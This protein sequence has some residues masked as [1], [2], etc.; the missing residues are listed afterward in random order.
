MELTLTTPAF[1]PTV[2][3]AKAFLHAIDHEDRQLII[4]I[5]SSKVEGVP[6]HEVVRRHGKLSQQAISKHLQ[7]LSAAGVVEGVPN[8]KKRQETLYFM[9]QDYCKHAVDVLAF[10]SA[11]PWKDP[12]AD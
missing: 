10:F 8:P 1:F 2:W 4:A 9:C 12:K 5:I 3:K 6:V 7:V 11:I